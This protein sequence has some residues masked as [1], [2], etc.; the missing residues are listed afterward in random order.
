VP[1][2]IIAARH[3]ASAMHDPTEGGIRAGLHEIAFASGVR[4]EV[5]LERI[6][7]GRET[8]AICRHYAIDPLGLIGSGALL[9]VAPPRRVPA[10]VRT[11]ARLGI[12]G[13]VIGSVESGRGV[14]AM[15]EGRRVPFPWVVRDEIIPALARRGSAAQ[16]S[17]DPATGSPPRRSG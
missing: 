1:E 2:A 9:V 15:R 6:P 13:C 17:H 4:L 12:S 11:W 5:D 14:R 7:I 3:G 8:A 10:L 16:V